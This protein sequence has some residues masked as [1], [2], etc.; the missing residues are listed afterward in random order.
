M[1]PRYYVVAEQDHELQ[2]PTSVE[3]LVHLGERLRLGPGSRVLDVASG[4][5]GPALVGAV[6]RL[7]T[8]RTGLSRSP[9]RTRHK[10]VTDA[11]VRF[12]GW[13]SSASSCPLAA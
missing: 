12:A 4:R 2:N 1:I 7:E 8:A 3:K 6:R 13:A 9:A 5:G 10:A 11:A